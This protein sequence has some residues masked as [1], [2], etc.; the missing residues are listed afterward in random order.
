VQKSA[1]VIIHA[2]LLD[3]LDI[4]ASFLLHDLFLSMT[5]LSPKKREEKV[6][7]LKEWFS[8]GF[9]RVDTCWN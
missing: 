9:H 8:L 4:L 7:V 1:K 6:F 3:P 2:V 5:G